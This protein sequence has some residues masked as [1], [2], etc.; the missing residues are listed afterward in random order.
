MLFAPAK[1]VGGPLA[2]QEAAAR[3]RANA[4]AW[5]GSIHS[6]SPLHIEIN[7]WVKY[8]SAGV[9]LPFLIKRNM[10]VLSLD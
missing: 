1:L 2:R 7:Q 9:L 10:S 4:F 3:L 8:Q 6:R 5:I